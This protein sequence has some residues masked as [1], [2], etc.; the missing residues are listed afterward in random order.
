MAVGLG[1]KG[2]IGFGTE[3]TWGSA[4]APS[5]YLELNSGA[6]GLEVTEER[7]HTASVYSINMDKDNMKKGAIAVSGDISFDARYE[8]MEKILKVAFGNVDTTQPEGTE[9]NVYQHEFSITDTLGTGLTIEIGKDIKAFRASGCMINNLTFDITNTGFLVVTLGIIGKDIGTASVATPSFPSAELIA[10]SE[11]AI[12]WGTE[13]VDIISASITLNNNLSDDRRFI[14]S[15]YIKQ[16][17]RNGKI[18]VTGTLTMEFED[19]TK[20]EDFRNAQERALNL[21]FTSSGTIDA[22][23]TSK[24]KLEIDCPNVRFTGGLPKIDDEGTI[25]IELPFKAYSDGTDKE[26]KVTLVNGVS[27]V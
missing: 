15:R 3:A 8:G 16:P 21:T 17:Q 18:E 26:M 11:G 9:V 14:G 24:Y 13:S 2:Y 1:Y 22:S 23:G 27:S 19:I 5:S 7:I 10:F 25:N 6:D 12:T 4:V 20:Y